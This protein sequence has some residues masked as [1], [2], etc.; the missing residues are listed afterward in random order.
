MVLPLVFSKILI[1]YQTDLNYEVMSNCEVNTTSS[2]GF[3]L[4][5][6]AESPFQTAN[7][8]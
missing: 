8:K 5:A 3:A 7:A 6:F 2:N 4:V 1:Y